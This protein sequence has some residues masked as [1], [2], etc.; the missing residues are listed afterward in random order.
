MEATFRILASTG[1]MNF[2]RVTVTTQADHVYDTG[3]SKER[4]YIYKVW[5]EAG[6]AGIAEVLKSLESS[7][8]VFIY[9]IEGL[10]V[11]TF[12]STVFAAAA[13]A[14]LKLLGH[15]PV[16]AYRERQWYALGKTYQ[17]DPPPRQ[18]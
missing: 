5:L 16:V 7:Q 2:A 9:R 17:N 18:L 15:E 12:G 4:Y 1:H 14:T 8:P 3:N 10:E 11:D 6:Q 13:A